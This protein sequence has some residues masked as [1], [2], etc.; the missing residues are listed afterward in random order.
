MR[1]IKFH[2]IPFFVLISA[3]LGVNL[4]ANAQNIDHGQNARLPSALKTFSLELWSPDQ[5]APL[6]TKPA[7]FGDNYRYRYTPEQH[8]F[9][10]TET[11]RVVVFSLN[12]SLKARYQFRWIA[13]DTPQFTHI[14]SMKPD[15]IIVGL[16]DGPLSGQTYFELWIYDTELQQSFMCDPEVVIR[17]PPDETP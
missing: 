14:V 16:D 13:A 9:E 17:R 3:V 10:E 2:L 15:E 1:K 11:N 7:E 5:A 12:K 8:S 6:D 4:T